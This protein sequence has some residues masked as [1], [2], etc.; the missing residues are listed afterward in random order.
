[1]CGILAQ[2]AFDGIIDARD[3]AGRLAAQGH[4]GPDGQST[5]IAPDQS[6][7]LGHNLLSL[8]GTTN[9]RQPLASED[10]QTVASVNGEFYGYQHIRSELKGKGHHHCWEDKPW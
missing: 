1:M 7:A 4:R 6:V 2:L 5:W 9:V 3:F 10:G 8:T